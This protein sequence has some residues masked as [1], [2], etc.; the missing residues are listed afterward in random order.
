MEIRD[1]GS[2]IQIDGPTWNGDGFVEEYPNRLWNR[3]PK[4]LRALAVEEIKAEN[5]PASMLDNKDRGI[6]LLAFR[7][8][9][10]KP[11]SEDASIRVHS[12]HA[13]GNYCYD[14]TKATYE[15]LESGCFLSFANPD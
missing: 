11:I 3:L 4:I 7:S 10:L 6:V 14:D 5:Q 12:R 2:T 9:P 1:L 13:Y 8:G 15:D